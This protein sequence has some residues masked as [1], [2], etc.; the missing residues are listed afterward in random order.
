MSLHRCDSI[1]EG[2]DDV[3]VLRSF[4]EFK[5][6]RLPESARDAL[7]TQLQSASVEVVLPLLRLLLR[8]LLTFP[9][10]ALVEY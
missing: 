9:S 6:N 4:P 1:E 5:P 7:R 3:H 8:R 10:I 2:I